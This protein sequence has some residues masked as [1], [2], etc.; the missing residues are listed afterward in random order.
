MVKKLTLEDM[1]ALAK[2]RG[3][4]CLS[5]KYINSRTKLTWKCDKGHIWKA[6]QSNIKNGHW[7]PICSGYVY[8]TT[9]DMHNFATERGGKFLKSKYISASSKS[10]WECSKGHKFTSN[11]SYVKSGYWCP[12]CRRQNLKNKKTIEMRKYARV[13]GWRLLS[14]GYFSTTVKSEWKCRKGHIFKRTFDSVKAGKGCPDCQ[15]QKEVKR[16]TTEMHED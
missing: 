7:C 8:Y 12:E 3:G 11:F 6:T 5:T 15:K 13:K 4:Q 10:D 2:Q 1:H 9:E 14:D 16:K